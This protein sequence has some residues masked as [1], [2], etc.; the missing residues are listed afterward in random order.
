MMNHKENL[1]Y[2]E[3]VESLAAMES[4]TAMPECI[5]EL[6][7]RIEKLEAERG[8][9]KAVEKL[10]EEN[11]EGLK[12]LAEIEVAERNANDPYSPNTRRV[13]DAFWRACLGEPQT[14]ENDMKALAA[15]LRA[16]AEVCVPDDSEGH[17]V[18][19]PH[20]LTIANELGET[21]D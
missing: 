8:A 4:C 9:W 14:F 5:L 16:V 21:N 1:K 12:Q 18:Y 6:R 19:I 10:Y 20:V 2:W 7:S 3:R 13:A 15:A 11:G 17:W